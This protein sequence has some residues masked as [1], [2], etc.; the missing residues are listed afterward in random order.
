MVERAEFDLHAVIADIVEANLSRATL[1]GV[2]FG[3]AAI[4]LVI[5]GFLACY[6]GIFLVGVILRVA[7]M[8]K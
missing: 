4:G 8:A 7:A 3:F 2:L 1:K 6:F 5:A